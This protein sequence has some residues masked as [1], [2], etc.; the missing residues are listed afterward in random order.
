MTDLPPLYLQLVVLTCFVMKNAAFQSN[1]IEYYNLV[2]MLFDQELSLRHNR[3]CFFSM[4]NPH[5]SNRS[6]SRIL[7][8]LF[9]YD[10]FLD[11]YH[12]PGQISTVM[13]HISCITILH[14]ICYMM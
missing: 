2:E 12:K 7:S 13:H 4:L 10:A 6:N 8:I 1:R 9:L 14:G 3:T 5:V 11:S